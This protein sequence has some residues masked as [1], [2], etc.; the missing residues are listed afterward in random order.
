MESLPPVTRPPPP[1]ES[2]VWDPERHP[3]GDITLTTQASIAGDLGK[4][5]GYLESYLRVSQNPKP[6][7][8]E[9]VL[10]EAIRWNR[11]EII[12]YLLSNGV[13]LEKVHC[14]RATE[15]KSAAVYE[16]FLQHGWDINRPLD[17]YEPPALGYDF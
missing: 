7:E 2:I 4:V 14:Y 9:P 13:P 5:Q 12:A 10:N 16:V 8:F 6:Y 1:S 3:P 11:P 17:I 15:V